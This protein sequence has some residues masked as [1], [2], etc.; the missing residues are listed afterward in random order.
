MLASHQVA[1]GA[2]PGDLTGASQAVDIQTRLA[3]QIGCAEE[4]PTGSYFPG[5]WRLDPGKHPADG[6]GILDQNSARI[7][8]QNRVFDLSLWV[9]NTDQRDYRC[10]IDIH[11]RIICQLDFCVPLR[12]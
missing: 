2:W 6:A 9:G 5:P 7:E 8:L 10:V 4:W 1:S 3:G 12:R 11:H